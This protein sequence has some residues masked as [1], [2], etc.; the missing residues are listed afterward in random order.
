[1]LA[2]VMPQN[3]DVAMLAALINLVVYLIIVGIVVWLLIYLVD[4]I[5]LPQPFHRIA[6]VAITVIGVLIV[7]LALLQFA[8]MDVGAPRMVR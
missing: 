5:P 6:R 4:V 8:G 2:P 1:M 3:G 7:I